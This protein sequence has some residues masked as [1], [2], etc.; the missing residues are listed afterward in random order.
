M[1][2]TAAIH[3]LCANPAHETGEG[4]PD[5]DRLTIH[6]GK[7]AYCPRDAR[8]SAHEWTETGGVRLEELVRP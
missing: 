3:Y 4:R 1:A 6:D 7:W 5:V 8:A 2:A